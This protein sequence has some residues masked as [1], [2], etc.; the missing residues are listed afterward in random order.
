MDINQHV[1]KNK[2]LLNLKA[3]TTYKMWFHTNFFIPPKQ[4]KFNT[5]E[6]QLKDTEF[7]MSGDKK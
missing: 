3:L 1:V 7:T 5:E 6:S 4:F 2:K